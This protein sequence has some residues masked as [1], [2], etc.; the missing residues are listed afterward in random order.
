MKDDTTPN[1]GSD[2]N[3][4]LQDTSAATQRLQI[5]SLLR[6]NSLNTIEL[7]ERSHMAPAP[8]IKELRSKG[9][10][11]RTNLE[12]AKDLDGVLHKRV[13]RYTLL[14]EPPPA[15]DDNREGVA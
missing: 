5:L 2:A 6:V 3:P 7:R 13:A 15:N 9:Y 1:D 8:R 12:D 4:N 10:V 14:S 11:I